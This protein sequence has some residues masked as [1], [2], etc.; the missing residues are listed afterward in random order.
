MNGAMVWQW[1]VTHHYLLAVLLGVLLVLLL[2]MIGL[3]AWIRCI[4]DERLRSKQGER[5]SM[6]AIGSP[7]HNAQIGEMVRTTNERLAPWGLRVPEKV[8]M[9]IIAMETPVTHG[10]EQ[11]GEREYG[12]DA[13]EQTA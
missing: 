7:Q 1:V 2:A 11:T 10:P 8:A 12:Q 13:G 6:Y 4:R 3:D 5:P 9:D